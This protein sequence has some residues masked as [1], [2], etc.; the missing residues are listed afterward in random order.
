MD[1]ILNLQGLEDLAGFLKF[2][3]PTLEHE[4]IKNAIKTTFNGFKFMSALK[5]D[6]QKKLKSWYFQ[7]VLTPANHYHP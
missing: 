1:Y 6:I 2:P 3:R 5:K 4:T 7:I